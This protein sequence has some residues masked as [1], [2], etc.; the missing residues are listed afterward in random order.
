MVDLPTLRVTGSGRFTIPGLGDGKISGSGRISPEEIKISGNGSLPGGIEVPKLRKSGSLKVDGDLIAKE[1]DCSGSTKVY[2]TITTG[3]IENSGSLSVEGSL[4]GDAM[5]TS[6]S[7]RIEGA[8]NLSDRLDVSGSIETGDNLHAGNHIRLSGSFYISGKLSTKELEV[9][10]NR[11]KSKVED[12]IK[13]EH[14]DVKR[15]D[16]WRGRTPGV[17]EGELITT[18]ITGKEVSLENVTCDNICGEK[19]NIGEGCRIRGKV[20]YT[21]E[22]D[23]DEGAQLSN[24]PEKVGSI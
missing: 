5:R 4:T 16:R 6:G 23:V 19:V 3:H 1:I 17:R 21:H 15:H 10:L 13:A 20:L 18:S 12:G 22:I 11:T 14:I 7:T 2:G 24:S 8:I 9:T